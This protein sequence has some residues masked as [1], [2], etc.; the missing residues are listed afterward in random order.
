ME[1]CFCQ[2][3]CRFRKPVLVWEGKRKK[4]ENWKKEMG[5]GKEGRVNEEERKERREGRKC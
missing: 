5:G 2:V 1:V 3:L 4:K